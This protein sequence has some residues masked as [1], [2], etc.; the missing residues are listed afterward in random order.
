MAQFMIEQEDWDQLIELSKQARNA[1]VMVMSL[2]DGLAGRDFANLAR[3]RVFAFW[4][5]LGR[6]Y[7]FDGSDV[8]PI[9]G[10]MIEARQI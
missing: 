2:A 4:R 7:G 3:E 8:K 5:K 10:R 6:K 1:P 9:S